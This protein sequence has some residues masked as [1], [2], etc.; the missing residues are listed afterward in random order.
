[1]ER[2]TDY[3]PDISIAPDGTLWALGHSVMNW[4]SG[5]RGVFSLRD[6]EWTAHALPEGATVTG[7]ETPADGSVWISEGAV[8]GGQGCPGERNV[9]AGGRLAVARLVDGAWVEESIEPALRAGDGGSLAVGPDGTALLGTMYCNSCPDGAWVG[10]VERGEDG[11]APSY[12]ADP[13]PDGV[14]L[15]TGPIA[16]GADGTVWA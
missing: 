11:W 2:S 16:I 10:I 8:E 5:T 14:R 4:P 12:T 6:G 3:W 7:I 13:G 9:A 15:G 1:M